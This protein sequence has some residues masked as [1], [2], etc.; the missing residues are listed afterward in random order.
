MSKSCDIPR[1]FVAKCLV[2]EALPDDIDDYVDLWHSDESHPDV[3]LVD[4]LGFSDLE[5]RLW[6]ENPH[7]LPL[8]LNASQRGVPLSKIR[9]YDERY[10]LAARGPS[11]ESVDEL[12][13][14]LKTTGRIPS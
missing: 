1:N 8:I 3:S 4:F 5:Y 7:A 12:T 2:G 9:D 6:A 14:W 11:V 13:Q 10:R